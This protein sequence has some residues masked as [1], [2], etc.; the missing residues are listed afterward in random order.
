MN[1]I[2]GFSDLLLSHVKDQKQLSQIKSIRSSSKNLLTLINDI[3]DLS[4]IE[5]GKMLIQPE[6][7]NI[8]MIISEIE[9]VFA[10]RAREKGIRFFVETEK[11][12]PASLLMV[13]TH[14]RQILFN[15]LDNAIKFTSHGH[16]I[17]TIDQKPKNKNHLDL[18]LSVEDT[19]IS[20]T[21]DQHEMIFESFSQ[22]KGL[23]ERKYGGTGLGLTISRRLV[24]LM[25]GTLTLVSK[26]GK[27]TIFTLLLPDIAI[28]SEPARTQKEQFIDINKIQFSESRI[29]IVDDNY[30][31]RK[32]L[33]DLFENSPVKVME[34]MNGIEAIELA[35]KFHPD[36][37]LMDLR[38]PEMN[39]YEATNM[40]KKQDRTKDIPVIA[41][42]ASPKIIING[43]SDKDIFDDFIMK[44]VILSDLVQHLKKYLKQKDIPK[45]VR[46]KAAHPS[47]PLIKMTEKQKKV[48]KELIITLEN[49]HLPVF[50]EVLAQQRIG[51]IE[52]FGHK[53]ISLGEQSGSSLLEE[54]GKGICSTAETFDTELLMNNLSSF[55]EIIGKLKKSLKK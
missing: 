42:S 16:V 10:S 30:E 31:N 26:P 29:L 39:G 41:L 43:Q 34:A 3:L 6:S 44:P 37:I 51:Q 36:L 21:E 47:R 23:P 53:L 4:K 28:L 50:R 35:T 27:G 8:S 15:L 12:I 22:L 17:L 25:G 46:T 18:I 1:S 33:V 14:F 24:E 7:V 54:Y 49:E 11:L 13:E 5:A 52:S 45:K 2:I 20:I 9:L 32:L 40:L 19:G 55:P 38:M 48:V